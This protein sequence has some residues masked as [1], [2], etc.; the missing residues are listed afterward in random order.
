MT[1]TPDNNKADYSIVSNTFIEVQQLQAQLDKVTTSITPMI[2][3]DV[4][5]KEKLSAYETKIEELKIKI[6]NLLISITANR[7][8]EADLKEKINK[9]LEKISVDPQ[10]YWAQVSMQVQNN[11]QQSFDINQFDID[12]PLDEE[13]ESEL[14]KDVITDFNTVTFPAELSRKKLQENIEKKVFW[15]TYKYERTSHDHHYYVF[16]DN[17]YISVYKNYPSSSRDIYSLSGVWYFI[18]E[19]SQDSITAL[20]DAYKNI[21]KFG[22]NGVIHYKVRGKN[23]KWA[24]MGASYKFI[25]WFV[26]GQIRV[27]D[28]VVKAQTLPVVIKNTNYTKYRKKLEGIKDLTNHWSEWFDVDLK[29]KIIRNRPSPKKNKVSQYF[30]KLQTVTDEEK[31]EEFLDMSLDAFHTRDLPVRTYN[32]LK[33]AKISN[34]RQLIEWDVTQNELLK[35]RNT[36]R[37]TILGIKALLAQYGLSDKRKQK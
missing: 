20:S 33:A 28:N 24:I 25:T 6:S 15:H 29:G 35:Y 2:A 26:Y 37:K 8:E 17:D 14:I 11:L 30:N 22:L 1:D 31:I 21:D 23:W 12:V 3:Q 4:L 9:K 7:T 16:D 10:T 18:W 34:F 32:G 13:E 5:L 19:G 36:G 27:R